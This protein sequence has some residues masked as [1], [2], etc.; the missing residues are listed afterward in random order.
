MT[1]K[2]TLDNFEEYDN[3]IL[4]DKENDTYTED[5]TFLEKWASKAEGII[6]D[7]ACCTGRGPTDKTR[8][9]YVKQIAT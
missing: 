6:I 7:L 5:I 8:I 9:L 1:E 2:T 4:Y 3:P